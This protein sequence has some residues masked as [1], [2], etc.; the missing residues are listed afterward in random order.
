MRRR[1]LSNSRRYWMSAE[2]VFLVTGAFGAL[3]SHLLRLLAE[4]SVGRVIAVARS[5]VGR[6]A[7]PHG[8]ELVVGDLRHGEVWAGLPRTITHVFHLAAA[9]PWQRGKKAQASVVA[10]NLGPVGHLLEQRQHWPALE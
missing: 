10:D 1:S 6:Q 9:I 8:V 5:G 4:E 2:R 7:L 3:A